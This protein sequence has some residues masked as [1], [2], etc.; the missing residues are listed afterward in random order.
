MS[1]VTMTSEEIRRVVTPE[2]I[3]REIEEARK[4]PFVY[5]PE[6]PPL[7]KEQLKKFHR[8]NSRHTAS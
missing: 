7:T 4:I 8:A 2:R 3:E 1:I 5:D 6:C